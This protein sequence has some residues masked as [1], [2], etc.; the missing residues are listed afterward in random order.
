M[1]L[2]SIMARGASGEAER[3]MDLSGYVAAWNAAMDV[4]YT[5]VPVSVQSAVTNA[6]CS[7][8]IDT[9][10][11]SVAQTP[12]D[13]V[14]PSGG[15]RL[16]IATPSLIAEPSGIVEQDVWIYQL[17]D[18]MAS[19]GNAFGEIVEYTRQ[20]PSMIETIDAALVSDRRVID[21]RKSA[22]VNGERRFFWPH[23]ELWHVP[24]KFT[25]AGNPFAE[26]PINRARATIGAAIAARDFGS[27][28]FG[29]GSHPG[30]LITSERELSKEQA[31]QIKTAFLNAVKGT[32]EPAVLGAGLEYTPLIID[33]ND[34]Q[35]LDLMRFAVEEACRFW[36]VPPAMV[37]AASSGQSVTY[38]NATQ[39]DLSYLKHSLE[40]YYRRLERALGRLLPRPQQVKF[41]RNA[42]LSSD[43]ASRSE[44]VDRRLKNRTMTVNEARALEDE[45]PFDDPQFD[46]P[47]IDDAR[48]LS[49]AEAIQKVYLGVTNGV[50]T[51]DEARQIVNEAGGNL[52]IPG[53][54]PAA[55][56]PA[57]PPASPT[58]QP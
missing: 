3:S 14:R 18:S 36:K 51:P 58:P 32:R 38:A 42:F 9:L 12:I 31:Q 8:V 49:A 20:L 13:V 26:S 29:D 44:I 7:A 19:D 45:P 10:A 48:D 33:P 37:Y 22:L 16:P 52:D 24:G 50:V 4:S 21:G 6:A 55:P 11:T 53:P 39:A 2:R 46:E 40:V 1:G 25:R 57:D 35:F 28:F 27:R 56:T 5:P 17:V 23:G 41:N 43:P 30:G 54:F 15:S 47:G 34:S